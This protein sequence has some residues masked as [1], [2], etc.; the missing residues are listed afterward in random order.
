MTALSNGRRTVTIATSLI[1]LI[2]FL[3]ICIESYSHE[4]KKITSIN[5]PEDFGLAHTQIIHQYM[6]RIL[7]SDEEFS[8][9]GMM[10]DLS[11]E[12]I[13]SLNV[14]SDSD[15][16]YEYLYSMYGFGDLILGE[17]P[18][19][20][21]TE[22]GVPYGMY[23][24][25]SLLQDYEKSPEL[26]D[27]VEKY[28]F[29]LSL[30]RIEPVEKV[31]SVMNNDLEAFL[32]TNDDEEEEIIARVTYSVGMESLKQWNEELTPGSNSLLHRYLNSQGRRR[33]LQFLPEDSGKDQ[34]NF[35]RDDL[36]DVVQGDVVGTVEGILDTIFGGGF[37]G[38]FGAV[39]KAT[40]ASVV[41]AI[42]VVVIRVGCV[43]LPN[44]DT[45]GFRP[46]DL[47]RG[48]CN[49][50]D[51]CGTGFFCDR[52]PDRPG[53]QCN[54]TN[55]TT[56]CP[57]RC[58]NFPNLPGCSDCDSGGDDNSTAPCP[59]YCGLFPGRPA[60]EDCGED[61]DD[62][63]GDGSP[64]PCPATCNLFPNRPNCE[65][66]DDGDGG[67]GD[68]DGVADDGDTG[69]DTPTDCPATCNLF[70]NRPQ[71]ENCPEDDGGDGGDG[72]DVTEDLGTNDGDG[73]GGDGDGVADDGDTGGD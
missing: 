62:G 6:E 56:D 44:I 46:L 60:C 34:F 18:V 45:V 53:C 28:F 73:D 3:S 30:V 37:L 19:T 14:F 4:S 48:F 67:D 1:G 17:E 54:E 41:A 9:Q 36:V 55:S 65:N 38:I 33:E 52:F 10:N 50:E 68:G 43:K 64:A 63:G 70:P 32:E 39:G 8:R 35:S 51:E 12:I 22:D 66:C 27:L 11:R 69:G 31:L 2:T 42:R 47:E 25:K 72:E 7:T 59:T 26:T 49:N 58:E 16:E 61:G 57:D 23:Y 15:S 13:R 5:E 21:I 24:T 29:S 71:C 40:T 20:G